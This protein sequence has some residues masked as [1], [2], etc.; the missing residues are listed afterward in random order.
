MRRRDFMALAGSV[1]AAR[2]LAARAQ[3]QRDRVRRVSV[4]IPFREDAETL[5]LVA[6]FKQRFEELGWTE[7]RNVQLDYRYTDGDSERTRSASAELLAL[8][9][10]AILAYANP[11]VASLMP[12]THTIPIVFTQASDPVGS[13][14]VSNL[15]HQHYRLSQFRTC[16]CREMDGCAQATCALGS[17]SCGSP[18]SWH[19]RQYCLRPHSRICCRNFWGDDYGRRRAQRRRDRAYANRV[20]ERAGWRPDRGAGAAYL[21]QS[22]DDRGYGNAIASAG[23]LFLPLLRHERRFGLIQY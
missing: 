7:G 16:D 20:C 23:G 18:R 19:C 21:R 13:G 6:A 14:F 17:K 2:P 22:S 12:L 4:L 10:D 9:P 3:Q 11:A 8:A 15:A 1:A 5:V